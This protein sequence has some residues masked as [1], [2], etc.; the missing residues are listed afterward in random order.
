MVLIHRVYRDLD[1]ELPTEYEDLKLKTYLKDYQ[2]NPYECQ[3]KLMGLIRS[4]GK[5]S[6][7]KYPKRGDL[8]LV[9]QSGGKIVKPGWLAAIYTGKSEAMASFIETGVSMFK[10]D[11]HNRAIM[12]RTII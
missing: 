11:R 12:A 5:K 9:S 10:L 7:V 1:V 6:S 8:L 2:A 3:I 4:L